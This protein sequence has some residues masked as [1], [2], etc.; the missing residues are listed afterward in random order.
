[1]TWT[2]ISPSVMVTLTETVLDGYTLV[3]EQETWTATSLLVILRD[4]TTHTIP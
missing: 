3:E 1:M 2:W 4:I